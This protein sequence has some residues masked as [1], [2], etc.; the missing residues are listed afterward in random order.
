MSIYRLLTAAGREPARI[1]DSELSALYAHPDP[2]DR[3]WVRTNFVSTLDGAVQGRDGRSGTINTA[4]DRAVF[5]LLRAHADV[6]LVGAGTARAEHYRAVDLD[7]RQVAVREQLGLAPHPTLAIVSASGDLAENLF[8]G[9]ECGPVL[10]LTSRA[11]RA[12]RPQFAAGIEVIEFGG[13]GELP[14]TELI[15][16][17]AGRGLRRVLCEGGPRLNR[18]LHAAGLVDDL[19]LTLSPLVVAGPSARTTIGD[20]I[21]EDHFRLE[22]ALGADDSTLLL[23]YLRAEHR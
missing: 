14:V 18:Q 19:C 13:S 16:E 6:V 9:S 23:R 2:G 12:D 11:S 4:S 20:R 21:E 7:D 22:H 1:T 10:I 3:A 5:A 8:A 15:T 17:L